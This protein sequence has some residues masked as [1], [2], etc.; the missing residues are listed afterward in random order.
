M[1]WICYVISGFS[2]EINDICLACLYFSYDQEVNNVS[3]NGNQPNIN[4]D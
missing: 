4:A 1:L 3:A 2:V